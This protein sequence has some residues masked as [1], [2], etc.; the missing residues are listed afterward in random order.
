MMTDHL[1]QFPRRPPAGSCWSMTTSRTSTSCA[2]RSVAPKYRLFVARNGEDA[3][4]VARR[5][6]PSI[7]LLDVL[8]PGIDGDETCRRLKDDAETRDAAV[9]FLSALGDPKDKVR[10]FEVGAVD[11]ITKP[12]QAG[13]VIA[14][15][16]THLTIQRL[17]HRQAEAT[18][19]CRAARC[20]R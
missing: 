15:V 19:A 7:V 13:E 1:S 8:M 18:S 12:F 6:R 16:N 17:L 11:F 20:A 10:G 5:A 9:I 2:R 14:R 3:L 4:K